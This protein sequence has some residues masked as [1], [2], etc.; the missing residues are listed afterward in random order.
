[1]AEGEA[2]GAVNFPY[3]ERYASGDAALVREVLTVFR[4]EAVEWG[5]RLHAEGG[6]WRFLV[7][8]LKG[9]SR[10]I[11]AGA[12]GDLCAAAERDGGASLPKV[13]AELEAVL[14]EISAYLAR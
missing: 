9:T 10:T 1:M 2:F 11:G 6:D 7:H 5:G 3:L 8:S 13:R 12:L 4:A 14:A